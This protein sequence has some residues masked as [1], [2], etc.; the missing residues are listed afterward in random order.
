MTTFFDFPLPAILADLGACQYGDTC[1]R[2]HIKPEF[3]QT[4]LLAHMYSNPIVYQEAESYSPDILQQVFNALF[5]VL[6]HYF[7]GLAL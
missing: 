4:V 5:L 2:K 3:S 7:L 6:I 1:S